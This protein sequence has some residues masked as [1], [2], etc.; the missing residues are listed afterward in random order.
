MMS[1]IKE[2]SGI[3]YPEITDEDNHR[4]DRVLG[5]ALFD[6]GANFE[7][8]ES[9]LPKLDLEVNPSKLDTCEMMLNNL[10]TIAGLESIGIAHLNLLIQ[11]LQKKI[12][13]RLMSYDLG[14]KVGL[15]FVTSL[16]ILALKHQDRLNV[17]TIRLNQE[18]PLE[19]LAEDFVDLWLE[20]SEIRNTTR[21]FEVLKDFVN[22][23]EK[24]YLL[25]S[26]TPSEKWF[27]Q[28]DGPR[29]I[30]G[31]EDELKPDKRTGSQVWNKVKHY[32][33]ALKFKSNKVKEDSKLIP[34]MLRL[35]EIPL[36]VSQIKQVLEYKLSRLESTTKGLNILKEISS[37]S[38]QSLLSGEITEAFE[39]MFRREGGQLEYLCENYNGLNRQLVS[40]QI[41]SFAQMLKK[42]VEYVCSSE[43]PLET[44]LSAI[45]NLKWKFRGK[46]KDIVGVIDIESMLLH[47]QESPLIIESILE[48]IEIL[49]TFVEDKVSSI[50]NDDVISLII[51]R[52]ISSLLSDMYLWSTNIALQ[53]S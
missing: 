31:E 35:I 52:T 23:F 34:L 9:I 43:N 10:L 17:F 41:S 16:F 1:N 37:S 22:A 26:M 14:G 39:R 46:E 51:T 4:L 12:R 8:M 28:F 40:A 15:T 50:E 45:S 21:K 49:M 36:E 42:F 13:R 18:E 27:L 30:Q 20:S 29:L 11:E 44:K 5:S 53:I 24:I 19:S 32:I 47:N 33:T 3:S 38:Q 6:Q 7:L 48:L 25:F 2:S